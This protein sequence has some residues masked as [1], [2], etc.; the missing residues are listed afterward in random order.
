MNQEDPESKLNIEGKAEYDPGKYLEAFP[1]L[2]ADDEIARQIE[3]LRDTPL[4]GNTKYDAIIEESLEKDIKELE[5]K[6]L[7]E[8]ERSKLLDS[9]IAQLQKDIAL[10]YEASPNTLGN[11]LESRKTEIDKLIKALDE[12]DPASNSESYN[13]RKKEFMDALEECLRQVARENNWQIEI[14]KNNKYADDRLSRHTYISDGEHTVILDPS[15]LGFTGTSALGYNVEELEKQIGPSHLKRF[16]SL[17]SS[18]T[19]KWDPESLVLSIDRGIPD[20]KRI[21][22]KEEIVFLEKVIASYY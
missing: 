21:P 14:D 13:A 11:I 3:E 6:L 17:L 10:L 20:I 12:A 5:G 2:F 9:N 8:G 19:L 15:I 1:R 7:Q 18:A 22:T 4:T 16:A